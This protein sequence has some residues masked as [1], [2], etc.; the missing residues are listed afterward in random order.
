MSN[1]HVYTHV[2]LKN[3]LPEVKGQSW[4][5]PLISGLIVYVIFIL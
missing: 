5:A 1:T 3:K 4:A 2:H